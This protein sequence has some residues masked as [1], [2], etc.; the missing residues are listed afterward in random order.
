MGKEGIE[1]LACYNLSADRNDIIMVAVERAMSEFGLGPSV[2]EEE[3]AQIR[4]VIRMSI[5]AGAQ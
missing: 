5:R 1:M 3:R 4:A 2:S